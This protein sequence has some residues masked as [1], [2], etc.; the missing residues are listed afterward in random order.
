MD[1]S[2]PCLQILTR[3]QVN[4]TCFVNQAKRTTTTTDTGV[5]LEDVV[6]YYV[7]MS[8]LFDVKERAL[9]S[10]R[11]PCSK[12]KFPPALS[13]PFA[14]VPLEAEKKHVR[15][16]KH[17]SAVD[18]DVN[19]RD[20]Q[21]RRIGDGQLIGSGRAK[22]SSKVGSDRRFIRDNKTASWEKSHWPSVRTTLVLA[23]FFLLS[24]QFVNPT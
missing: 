9:Q 6:R 17:T 24:R 18:T 16:H 22:A 15:W 10:L 23:A 19:G 5:F 12:S 4:A 1:L 7:N 2:L 14:A 21:M 3:G 8:S 13:F 20:L 11:R